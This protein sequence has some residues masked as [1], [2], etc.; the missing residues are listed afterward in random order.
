MGTEASTG[1]G[2]PQPDDLTLLDACAV[3]NFSAT[4]WMAAILAVIPGR[5]AVVDHVADEALYVRRGGTGDDARDPEPIDLAPLTVSGILT[6]LTSEDEHELATFVALTQHLDD[7]EAMTAAL[8]I[9]RGALLVTDD[10]KAERVL[11]GRVRLRSTLDV[12]KAWVDAERIDAAH[13]RQVL[14]AISERA[15]YRPSRL[16]PLRRWWELAL[17]EG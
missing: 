11:A 16:H 4:G 17:G 12:V 3:I 10:R 9:H 15:T 8:A 14:V 1:R 13:V 5:V 2:S 6:V 7:G